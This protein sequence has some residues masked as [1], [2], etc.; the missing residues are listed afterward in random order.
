MKIFGIVAAAL[1]AASVT[2]SH[3]T[4]AAS[5]TNR[6]RIQIQGTDV[7]KRLG[8][9]ALSFAWAQDTV[10]SKATAIA[11]LDGMVGKLTKT[12]AADRADAIIKAKKFINDA[13]AAGVDPVSRSWGNKDVSAKR[14]DIEVITGKAFA[15]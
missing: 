10:V 13:P 8:K 12:E 14:V 2:V 6:G 1:L 3:T 9:D 5:P 15:N 11:E 4:I 7:E